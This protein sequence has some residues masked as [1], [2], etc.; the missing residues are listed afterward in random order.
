MTASHVQH[1]FVWDGGV[2]TDLNDLIGA[3]SGWILSEATGI[4]TDGQIVGVGSLDGERG[5]FLL[6]PVGRVDR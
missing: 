5:A 1:A 3:E 2:I 6:T 4:N